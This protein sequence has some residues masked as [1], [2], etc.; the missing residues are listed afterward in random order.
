M[1][2][3]GGRVL[4]LGWGDAVLN[5]DECNANKA[6]SWRVSRRSQPAAH[7]SAPAPHPQLPP[8]QVAGAPSPFPPLAAPGTS[9]RCRGPGASHAR[10]QSQRPPAPCSRPGD[11]ACARMHVWLWV[12]VSMSVCW[13]GEEVAVKAGRQACG[14]GALL[15]AAHHRSRAALLRAVGGG[16]PAPRCAHL[17]RAAGLAVCKVDAGLHS[18]ARLAGKDDALGAAAGR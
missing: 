16:R 6:A 17:Q 9:H 2:G 3:G 13:G 11:C 12:C 4:S 10:G 7:E 1:S 15:P 14:P 18:A 8:A 5:Q